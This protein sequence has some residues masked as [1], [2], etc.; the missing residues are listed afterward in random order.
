MHVLLVASCPLLAHTHMSGAPDNQCD[1]ATESRE[2]E[3]HQP[4]EHDAHARSTLEIDLTTSSDGHFLEH[5]DDASSDE[6]F[7]VIC[8]AE[9]PPHRAQKEAFCRRRCPSE[10]LSPVLAFEISELLS[11]HAE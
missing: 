3:D 9:S 8:G 10:P 6:F 1:I 7:S 11:S 5:V 4:A 2:K